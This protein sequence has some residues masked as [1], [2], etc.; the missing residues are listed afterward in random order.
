MTPSDH[1]STPASIPRTGAAGGATPGCAELG[2]AYVRLWE[3]IRPCAAGGDADEE[4]RLRNRAQAVLA[5]MMALRC[6][7]PRT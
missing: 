3:A 7:V 4:N 2:V 5:R 6:L 1:P